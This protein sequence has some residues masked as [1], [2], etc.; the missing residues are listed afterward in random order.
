LRARASL[1]WP[2]AKI[3]LEV[4]ESWCRKSCK[5]RQLIGSEEV[6]VLLLPCC[7]ESLVAREAQRYKRK[8]RALG[9]QESHHLT[10]AR[11]LVM[12]TKK[13][14]RKRNRSQRNLAHDHAP[15]APEEERV[16]LIKG[17]AIGAETEWR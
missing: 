9:D 17:G 16:N 14:L 5:E 11:H 3:S 15:A 10:I 1:Q 2:C 6:P 12:A 4:G 13:Q 8:E 7:G